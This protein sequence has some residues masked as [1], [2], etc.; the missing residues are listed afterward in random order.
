MTEVEQTFQSTLCRLLLYSPFS[1]NMLVGMVQMPTESIE[2]LGVKVQNGRITL[3]YNPKFFS[4]LEESERTFVLIHEMMHVLL[5]HC[6]HRTS[7]DLRRARKENVAMDLAI[8]CMI[9][10]EVGVKMPRFKEDVGEKKKG[11]IIGLLP[12]MFGFK[13]GLSYEQYMELLDKKFP[14]DTIVLVPIPGAGNEFGDGG[15][16]ISEKCPFGKIVKH[17]IDEKHGEGYDED[18]FIDDYVRNVVENIERN[19]SW[20]H[21]GVN[22]IE[23]VKKAQEQPLNWGDILRLK[24]GPF[25]SYQKLPSRRRWNKHY[26][27]PFLGSTTKSVEPVAVYADTSGSVGSADLSRFIVE[28]ERIANYTG[29]YLWSFDTDV[30]DPDENVLFTR[31]TI[32][33]IEFKGRGGTCFAP[34]FEHA[35][36]KGISQ[37]VVLTDGFADNISPEQ[38][39]GLEVIWVITKGG[40]KEGKAGTVIEMN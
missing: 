3:C 2:T 7:G 25:L 36:S 11:E 28:I 37:V 13:D 29:V 5:H 4:S 40:C 9:P 21:L 24:M 27:K 18:A 16:E 22:A 38:I 1:F 31:R 35:K 10:E 6:T 34:V 23:M 32:D 15:M 14:D 20:G 19:H 17:R 39:E 12:S 8:N 30:K 33:A 26:G